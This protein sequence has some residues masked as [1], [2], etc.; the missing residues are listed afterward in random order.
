NPPFVS[1]VFNIIDQL[2]F[3]IKA[4]AVAEEAIAALK[5]D[6]KPI[7]AF[8]STMGSFLADM[9]L[10]EGDYI[11]NT[12]FT[13][14][15][16]KA[17]DTVMRYTIV[18]V[19]GNSNTKKIEPYELGASGLKEY[20]ELE[21]KIET[22]GTGISISPIDL[23]I[24]KIE[25]AG[26]KVGEVTGRSQRI[27]FSDG[28]RSGTIENY[29]T[30]KNEIFNRFNNG[31]HN[32][33]DVV[34]LN[35]SG[36]TGASLHASATFKDQR[37]R[38]M[39]IHQIELN[40]NIEV[41]KR[42]R[43][44]RTGQVRK[45][46][47]K[48]VTTSI[49]AE[50]RLMMMMKSKMKSLDA[51]TTGNQKSSDE[52]LK[53]ED[54]L[55]KYGDEIVY[56]YLEE[57]EE[58][59]KLLLD[60]LHIRDT[61]KETVTEGA[62]NKVTGRVA[63]L[64]TS[65]QEKFYKEIIDRYNN[66]V[67]MLKANDNYDLETSFENLEAEPIK[68]QI[69]VAG[70][71]GR[72]AFGQDSINE[73]CKVNVLRKPFTKS[74]VE[75]HL[76]AAM[77]GSNPQVRS[78]ELIKK[79]GDF[80]P[81]WKEM[82]MG[83]LRR[84]IDEVQ[85]KVL[86]ERE[87]AKNESRILKLEEDIKLLHQE[88]SKRENKYEAQRKSTIQLFEFFKIGKVVHVVFQEGF[89]DYSL[90][91]VL[92]TDIDFTKD[93]PYAPSSIL[94]QIACADSRRKLTIPASSYSFI[95][96][97]VAKS[98]NIP[99]SEIENALKFW[100]KA[101]GNKS[102]EHRWIVTGNILQGLGHIKGKLIKFTTSAGEIKNGIKLSETFGR[103][104]NDYESTVPIEKAID[105]IEELNIGESLLTA[106]EEIK[107]TNANLNFYEIRIP[108]SLSR[109][110]KFYMDQELRKLIARPHGKR[111]ELG[112]FISIGQEMS[113]ML[114]KQNLKD[115]VKILNDKFR[116]SVKTSAI[117]VTDTEDTRGEGKEF[118]FKLTRPFGL[119]AYPPIGFL[120]HDNNE[121]QYG[122]VFYDRD[123]EI[124]VRLNF[125]IVPVYDEAEEPVSKWYKDLS[126]VQEEMLQTLKAEIKS[127]NQSGRLAALSNF[128]LS[129]NVIGNPE[130][131]FGEFSER[132]LA[133]SLAERLGLEV[134]E[135]SFLEISRLIKQLR[136]V[137]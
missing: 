38:V 67:A 88:L 129:T 136:L 20:E 71:G 5:A 73:L 103:E 65:D 132:E 53:S 6:K 106:G 104:E 100:D 61:E 62:A 94:L 118:E 17:L 83:V 60:P 64:A 101:N 81:G 36:A 84:D 25:N 96:S 47:Y 127:K 33:I 135:K 68:K 9:G 117:E 48:Y 130:F 126:P 39:I 89:D 86:E 114:H 23:I 77:S 125:S 69:I 111:D 63:I 72:S 80:F 42:G 37:T 50:K 49:P 18:D 7:I 85:K 51:N 137:A 87:G 52:S 12:D 105:L 54:F 123:L 91:I 134:T 32:K 34:L 41:Q 45:P 59:N 76:E 74:E 82:K 115:F 3:S 13:L 109:G 70:R 8:K 112:T 90:G 113:G 55:N 97:I 66:Y 30:K 43:I 57:N 1:K 131:T 124:K 92:G 122:T 58:F 121:G 44:N 107:F 110:G 98:Y 108:K 116:L 95:D 120:R 56:K 16:R 11:D 79:Y 119:G 75:E 31:G 46:E 99:A 102:K 21:E 14:T 19:M 35:Q 128:M 15:F 10:K 78:T 29:K 24:Y 26:Y 4:E 28:E 93:N 27:R 2:L 40:V 133:G 22:T